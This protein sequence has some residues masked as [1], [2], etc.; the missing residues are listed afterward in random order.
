MPDSNITKLALANS[1]KQLMIQKSFSEISVSN[2]ADDCGLTRQTFY[3]HF[4]D[5][6]DL[7]NWI[8]Y[9]ETA[10]I[11]IASHTSEFWTDSLKDLCYYMQQNKTFY[12]N[13]LNT[14]GQNS[15]PEY[16]REYIRNISIAAIDRVSDTEAER[17]KWEFTISFFA[18]AFVAFIVRWSNNGMQDDPA[19]FLSKMR[20][21][22]DGSVH[23]EIEMKQKENSPAH[24][25]TSKKCV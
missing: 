9:T 15:F 1:L 21:I 22:F 2:I 10:R 24:Q 14:T 4:K 8:Y 20:A 6:Y 11:M 16:L 25:E 5:K 19:L 13:A 23:R 12:K 3:Y 18:T 7:M 17:D